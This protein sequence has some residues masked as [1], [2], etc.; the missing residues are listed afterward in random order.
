MTIA[1]TPRLKIYY[2]QN[3]LQLQI[4]VASVVFWGII[5]ER[6]EQKIP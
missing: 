3:K 1:L 2:I 5:Y 4:I 6:V